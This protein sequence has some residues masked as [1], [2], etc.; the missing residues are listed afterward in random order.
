MK[1]AEVT[2][3]GP[4]QYAYPKPPSGEDYRIWSG[5]S[6]PVHNVDDAQFF[7]EEKGE[8]YEV[9]WTAQGRLMSEVKDDVSD[10]KEALKSLGYR[11]K[12]TLAKSFGIKANQT[13]DELEE[14]LQEVA[15]ELQEDMERQ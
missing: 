1:V 10:A 6:V 7:D 8:I 2:Y 9:D 13:E 12:Q 5:S 15:E 11:Q 4:M 14:E 3:V